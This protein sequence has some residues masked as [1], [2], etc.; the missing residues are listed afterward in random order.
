MII[1]VTGHRPQKFAPPN[2]HDLLTHPAVRQ[3][4][5]N[6]RGIVKWT[7]EQMKPTWLISGMALGV[8]QWAAEQAIEMGLPVLAAIPCRN[9]EQFW[10]PV[11]RSN[12]NALLSKCS[13][14]Q[15]VTDGPYQK[16]VMQTR[17]MWMVD[18]ANMVLAVFDGTEGGTANCVKYAIQSRRKIL[19]FDPRTL[20]SEWIG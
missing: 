6:V 19:R 18:R 16:H 14:V 13:N 5:A 17:N 1:A 9:Q 15:L 12:Y 20:K 3:V 10:G 8:D 2:T 4:E 7:I 11:A